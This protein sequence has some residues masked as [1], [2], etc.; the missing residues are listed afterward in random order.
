M[1]WLRAIAE[2][3]ALFILLVQ[4]PIPLFW[5]FVHPAVEFWRRHPRA[6]YYGV[7]FGSWGLVALA[8]LGGREWWLA[9]RFAQHPLLALA[10]AGLIGVDFWLLRRVKRGLGWRVLVGL[11][12]L[13]PRTQPLPVAARGI[14]GRVRHPRYLGMMLSY[15]GA[16]LLGPALRSPWPWVLIAAGAVVMLEGAAGF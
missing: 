8:L 3:V 13:M 10:G 9:E 6:C 4:L 11:P 1:E 14:Y 5:L 7:G 2:A 15:L 16:A 12:E